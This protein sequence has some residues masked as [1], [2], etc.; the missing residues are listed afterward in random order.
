MHEL[1]IEPGRTKRGYWHDPCQC[2]ELFHAL[3]WRDISI[4]YRLTVIAASWVLVRPLIA[5]VIFIIAFSRLTKSTSDDSARYP[6]MVFAGMLPCSFFSTSLADVSTNLISNTTANLVLGLYASPIGFTSSI[7]P[8][9][10][11]QLHWPRL[12]LSVGVSTSL[13]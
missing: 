4:G 6:L 7:I 1:I 13:A 5:M 8:D 2:G 10:W 9:Q 12:V 3:T 11:S